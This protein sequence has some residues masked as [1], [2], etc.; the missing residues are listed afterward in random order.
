MKGSILCNRRLEKFT[1]FYP[2]NPLTM[3]FSYCT[4]AIETAHQTARFSMITLSASVR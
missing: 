3:P 4:F 2:S 1:F